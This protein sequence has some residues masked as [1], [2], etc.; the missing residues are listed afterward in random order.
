MQTGNLKEVMDQ[1]K[2]LVSE[3]NSMAARIQEL[4]HVIRMR[5]QE[6]IM[7]QNMVDE[8]N[9]MRSEL[10]N[11]LEELKQM[12]G[13]F[14]EI[15]QMTEASRATNSMRHA[16][17][18]SKKHYDEQI[19]GLKEQNTLLKVQLNDLQYQFNELAAQIPTSTTEAENLSKEAMG[20][21]EESPPI[22]GLETDL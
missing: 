12:Q 17:I 8:A 4:E 19:A 7:L 22:D 15:K 18:M 3:G 9:A 20:W 5:D 10:E 11:Q 14:A 21:N 6:I 2:S 1:L 16:P 13:H